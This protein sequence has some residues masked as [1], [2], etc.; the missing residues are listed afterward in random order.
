MYS[1]VTIYQYVFICNYLSMCFFL[2]L[3]LYLY[4]S[5]YL[6]VQEDTDSGVSDKDNDTPRTVIDENERN[7][8]PLAPIGNILEFGK[9]KIM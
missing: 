4:L 1:S 6:F 2:Y 8:D 5:M 7:N 9:I 3:S